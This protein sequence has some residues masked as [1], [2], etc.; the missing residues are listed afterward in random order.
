MQIKYRSANPMVDRIVKII[1]Q[2]SPLE[3]ISGTTS[4]KQPYSA[5]KITYRQFTNWLV[6]SCSQRN[7]HMK[8]LAGN[9][10]DLDIYQVFGILGSDAS[11]YMAWIRL[12]LHLASE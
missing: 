12:V 9:V 1:D 8:R 11:K 4:R 3:P 2:Y 6:P 5:A 10:P 7:A